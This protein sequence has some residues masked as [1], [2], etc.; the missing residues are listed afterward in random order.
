VSLLRQALG[1]IHARPVEGLLESRRVFGGYQAFGNSKRASR[2]PLG[3][4]TYIDRSLE[5]GVGVLVEGLN[6]NEPKLIRPTRGTP[7]PSR[8]WIH[9]P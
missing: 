1:S 8:A 4:L 2:N 5:E 3:G 6:A 9:H 7:H